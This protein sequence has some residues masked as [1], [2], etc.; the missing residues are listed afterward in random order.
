MSGP[1]SL[2]E[3][4]QP[5]PGVPLPPLS[6][7]R[8]EH[9]TL[10]LSWMWF[11]EQATKDT[12]DPALLS[13]LKNSAPQIASELLKLQYQLDVT[14]EAI[15]VYY[16]QA[17][18]NAGEMAGVDWN[19]VTVGKVVRSQRAE[20]LMYG[21]LKSALDDYDIK[22]SLYMELYFFSCRGTF[23]CQVWVEPAD[24]WR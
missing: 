8:P 21:E 9:K 23:S 22:V 13:L 3:R 11:S 20:A 16:D 6:P 7:V 18:K 17:R 19:E 14:A 1:S 15:Q 5:A 12:N 10:V 2:P 24:G 4:N